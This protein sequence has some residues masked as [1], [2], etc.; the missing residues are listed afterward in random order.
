MEDT[1][2]TALWIGSQELLRNCILTPDE[3]T[4]EIDKVT[5]DDIVELMESIFIREKICLGVVGPYKSTARFEKL[6][7]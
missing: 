2:N 5:P 6:F 4:A 7:R 3:V 1:L